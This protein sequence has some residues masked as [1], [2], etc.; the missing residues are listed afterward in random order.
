MRYSSPGSSQQISHSSP[1]KCDS[2][3]PFTRGKLSARM[4]GRGC[5]RL[6]SAQPLSG[7]T[8]GSIP[9]PFP[10]RETTGPPSGASQGGWDCHRQGRQSR[11]GFRCL[12]S[13][14]RRWLRGCLCVPREARTEPVL[15]LCGSG[16]CLRARFVSGKLFL[17]AFQVNIRQI[18][19][20][21]SCHSL[22]RKLSE[23]WNFSFYFPPSWPCLC[24]RQQVP[25]V[26]G[27]SSRHNTEKWRRENFTSRNPVWRDKD[28]WACERDGAAARS[29]QGAWM[30]LSRACRSCFPR[31]AGAGQ[32]RVPGDSGSGDRRQLIKL[33][34]RHGN[35][36]PGI[37]VWSKHT[38]FD[39]VCSD[40]TSRAQLSRGSSGAGD[41]AA[42][43][44]SPVS[45][46]IGALFYQGSFCPVQFLSRANVQGQPRHPL[47][48]P[49]F[50]WLPLWGSGRPHSAPEYTVRGK[51]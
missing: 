13:R 24:R 39:Q 40:Y 44:I 26:R 23:L 50:P 9:F 7:S 32:P 33:S 38:A 8:H 48:L 46:S 34:R 51:G 27:M 22:P 14:G 37:R 5:C 47:T 49:S 1:S 35:S 42:W 19:T 18:L 17:L 29:G 11:P 6:P 2:P 28:V 12:F 45:F 3:F 21:L 43:R 10:A 36:V 15:G 20:P 16:S 31:R 30:S 41:F 25:L 4:A